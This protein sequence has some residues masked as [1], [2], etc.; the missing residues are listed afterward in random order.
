MGVRLEPSDE[1]M[2]EL[3]PEPNFNESMYIN[4]FDPDN[5]IGGFFRIGNRANEGYAEMTVCLYLPDG[6]VGFMFKRAE[7]IEQRRVRRR[8][9]DAGRWSRR[10]RSCASSY[11]GKVVLLD[12]P[13]EMAD[14]KKA[15]TEQPVRGVRRSTSRSPVRAAR[16]CSAASPT[17]RTRRPAR[18]SPR[19]TTSSSSPARD[20]SASASEEWLVDGLRPA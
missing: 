16:R 2:H 12:D 19:V 1:Y 20:G 9:H 3:G 18:S 6:Q 17:S 7:I 4:I 5:K 8:R 11:E 14:P 13:L 10:S 15:F